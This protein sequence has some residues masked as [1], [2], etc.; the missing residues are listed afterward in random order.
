MKINPKFNIGD[1]VTFKWRVNKTEC[2]L[3]CKGD[4]ERERNDGAVFSCPKCNGT[5]KINV[6]EYD[7]LPSTIKSIVVDIYKDNIIEYKYYLEG[8]LEDHYGDVRYNFI[9]DEEDLRH[10]YY[11]EHENK[12]KGEDEFFKRFTKD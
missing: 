8:S 5:G 11:M 12:E 3:N 6:K 7:I 9:F 1:R 4:G 10:F 2:C